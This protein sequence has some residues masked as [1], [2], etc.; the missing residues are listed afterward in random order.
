MTLLILVT[1][2]LSFVL[3][4]AVMV[5]AGPSR[6]T[7]D[8]SGVHAFVGLSYIAIL[9]IFMVLATGPAYIGTGDYV[10][11][12]ACDNGPNST[13]ECIINFEQATGLASEAPMITAN[14]GWT[15]DLHS[16]LSY[17]VC[18]AVVQLMMA[19]ITMFAR[20]GN[21]WNNGICSM[22]R[23][24]LGTASIFC[25]V[26]VSMGLALGALLGLP[27]AIRAETVMQMMAHVVLCV[28]ANV[29]STCALSRV[30]AETM[31]TVFCLNVTVCC[32][33]VAT[34][35]VCVVRGAKGRQYAP[36]PQECDVQEGYEPP[37]P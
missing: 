10:M 6:K 29:E 34:I 21:W 4:V 20:N 14:L 27:S 26:A 23:L 11:T 37:N 15:M 30:S 35:V 12:T 16:T 9:S 7:P 33:I 32:L 18:C 17:L 28:P 25:V 2:A 13:D 24:D 8:A 31:N 5:C 19:I 36:V 3:A 22:S 1:L